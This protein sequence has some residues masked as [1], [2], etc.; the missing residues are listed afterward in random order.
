M[1]ILYC[2]V[3]AN[4]SLTRE[5]FAQ[6]FPGEGQRRFG[7]GIS[8]SWIPSFLASMGSELP[9]AGGTRPGAPADRGVLLGLPVC[10]AGACC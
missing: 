9:S 1:D 3:L 7:G 4:R 6:V 10:S 8:V 2:L 5:H